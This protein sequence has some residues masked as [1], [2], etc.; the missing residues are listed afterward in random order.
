[1]KRPLTLGAALLVAACATAPAP[2]IS[3]DGLPATFAMSGRIAVRHG[4]EGE[5]ARLRW[6]RGHQSDVWVLAPPV[7]GEL[8]RIEGG[9]GGLVVHRP[10]AA[11]LAAASF[12]ELT[13][14]LLGAALDERLLVA[15]LHRRPMA[16]PEGWEVT[17]DE[18]Q[19]LGGR[20]VA[21]RI[22]ASRG[23][24]VVKLVVDGYE[25]RPE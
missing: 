5:M 10:G 1:M 23:E 15:W 11:P 16:G 13:E 24:T 14:N 20:D 17:I 7:G 25:A 9:P 18:S 3:L 21:R 4:A 2:V 8:A 12:S 6:E 22:T 19:R